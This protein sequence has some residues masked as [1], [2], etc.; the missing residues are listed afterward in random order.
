MGL[1]GVDWGI[2]AQAVCI[3]QMRTLKPIA[4]TGSRGN[5]VGAHRI[6]K[7]GDD[8]ILCRPSD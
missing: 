3:I 2:V 8:T 5:F 1:A 6:L 4:I 7:L